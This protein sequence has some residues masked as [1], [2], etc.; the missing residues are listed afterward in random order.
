MRLLACVR[1]IARIS[2]VALVTRERNIIY[3]ITIIYH[4]AAPTAPI[5]ASFRS[6]QYEQ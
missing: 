3:A 1:L 2:L 6:P 4:H 5:T